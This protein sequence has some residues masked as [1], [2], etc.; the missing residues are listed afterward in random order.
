MVTPEQW[1]RVALSLPGAEEKQHFEQP[2]FRVRD[3][4]FCGLSRDHTEGTLKLSPEAQAA[5]LD[6]RPEAFTPAAGA[7]GR[8]GWT[9]VTLANAHLEEC[10]ALIKESYDLVAKKK[11]EPK[12]SAKKA[13]TKQ[14]ATK[15]A[16]PKKAAPKKR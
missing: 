2:D 9:R 10:K 4:I 15:K 3:K 8:S 16:A 12:Q 1:R 5:A 13:T 11:P 14:T 7:W 6:A